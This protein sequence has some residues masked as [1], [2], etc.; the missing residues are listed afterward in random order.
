MT[1]IVTAAKDSPAQRADVAKIVLFR[2]PT[3]WVDPVEVRQ[4]FV[5]MTLTPTTLWK[6]WIDRHP[7]LKN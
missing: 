1:V 6:N 4:L 3:V 2:A 7:K 5:A